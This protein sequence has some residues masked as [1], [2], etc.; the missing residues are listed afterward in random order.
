MDEQQFME[1]VNL[2]SKLIEKTDKVNQKLIT[3]IITITIS[4]S[5]CLAITLTGIAYLYFTTD[6]SN[7]GTYNQIQGNDNNATQS[8]T[9]HKGDDI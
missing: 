7:Y 9:K 6:Y 1:V 4:F 2:T 3:A 8:G 5:L